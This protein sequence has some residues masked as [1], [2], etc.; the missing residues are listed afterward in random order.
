MEQATEDLRKAMKGF[1]TDEDVII[2]VV[3]SHDN[4]QR[5]EM[6]DC[7]TT[8][9][10]KNLIDDLKSELGGNLEDVTVAVMDP[11]TL[12]DAKCLRGAMKGAGTDE[13]C[14]IE[15]LC[16]K[17]NDK[18]DAI[19]E[20]YNTEFDRDLEEDIASETGGHFKR[21]L[22][23]QI[24]AGRDESD[25]VDEDL[26]TAD[27]QELYDAGEGQFGTDES[28]FN[29][30]LCRRSYPQL[31]LTFDKYKDIADKDIEDTI[32]AE[33]GGAL[34][35]GYLAIVKVCRDRPAFFAERLYKSMKGMGTDD[36]TLIRIV[37]ARSEIDL[38]DVKEAFQEKHETSL[39]EFISNDC[40]GDY[41]KMLLRLVGE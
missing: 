6:R 36:D 26:A 34:E 18:M 11:P 14:L 22:V 7:F 23:S 10:G 20:A 3:T 33:V 1:G 24:N 4:A 2:K 8:M 13:S 16:T 27:A 15:I 35:D 28:A 30:V 5:Q 9:Y 32:K 17:S 12:Y 21:L 38:A 39:G 41:K 25:D 31:N 29:M 19:K 40:G 37:V